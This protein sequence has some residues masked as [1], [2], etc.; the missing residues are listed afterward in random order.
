M[1][2]SGSLE[3]AA[4]HNTG[5]FLE[6]VTFELDLKGGQRVFQSEAETF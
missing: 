5:G 3:R 1:A 4:W 6:E 2:R